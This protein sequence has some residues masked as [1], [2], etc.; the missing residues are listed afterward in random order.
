MCLRS[1]EDRVGSFEMETREIEVMKLLSLAGVYLY[2][3]RP[4][5]RLAMAY[6]MFSNA[7]TSH[8]DAAGLNWIA[9]CCVEL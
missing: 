5:E 8:G 6:E 4:T 1:A 3:P 2:A 7:R 9:H